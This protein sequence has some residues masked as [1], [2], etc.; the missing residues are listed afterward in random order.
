MGFVTQLA[1]LPFAILIQIPLIL[2]GWILK[3]QTA[4]KSAQKIPLARLQI[5]EMGFVIQIAITLFAAM[6]LEI[7]GIAPLIVK[8]ILGFQDDLGLNCL[9]SCN[10][11]NCYYGL[12]SCQE[13]SPGCNSEMLGDS[14]CD[15]SCNIDLCNY[16]FGDCNN[17]QCNKDC[18]SWMIGDNNCNEECNNEACNWDGGDCDCSQGCHSY[19]KNNGIFK[20]NCNNTA[21]NYDGGDC[22][23]CAPGCLKSILGDGICDS[24]CNISGCHYD[25]YDC[26]CSEGCS[27]ESYG[28]CKDSCMNSYCLYDTISETS[29]CQ[30]QNLVLFSLHYAFISKNLSIN[31]SPENCTNTTNCIISEALDS[32][33]CHTNCKASSCIYSWNQCTEYTCA[34]SNCLSCN[35]I[36][37][38]DCFKCNTNTYQFYGYCL[39]SCPGGH[40]PI[41][42]LGNYP[43]CLIP[44]D[45][46]TRENP[47]VY[48]VTSKTST[49]A[50]EGN[51]TF[52]NPFASVSL[53][54]ASIYTKYSIVYLLNDG[55]HYLT[56]A[57]SSNP[58]STLLSDPCN[59]LIRNYNLTSLLI[60]SYDN[61][62]ILLKTKAGSKFPTFTITNITT[63]TIKNIIFNGEDILSNCSASP[64]CSYCANITL[65]SDGSYYND[66]GVKVSSFLASSACT[67]YHSPTLFN[68]YFGSKL[69]L[70][71]VNFISWRMELKSII[72]SY[73]GNITFNNVNFDNIRCN[74][75]PQTSAQSGQTGQDWKYAVV[76]FLDCGDEN[77]NCGSFEYANGIVSRL[78]NGYE[79]GAAQFSGFLSADKI[80]TVYLENVTFSSNVVYNPYASST[81]YSLIKLALF[82][83]LEVSHCVFQKNAANYGL[84][85]LSP[86]TLIFRNDVNSNNELIDLLLFHVY[87]HDTIFENNYGQYAGIFS[88]TYKSQ[89]QNILLKNNV[90]N[91]NG[92]LSGPIMQI[93]NQ[94]L[95]SDYIVD[96]KISMNSTNG[97]Y[98]EAIYKKREFILKDSVITNNYSGGKGIFDITQLVNIRIYNLTVESNGSLKTQNINTILWDYYVADSN[99]YTKRIVSDAASIDCF[100]LWSASTCYN[101]EISES[102]FQA[103]M[104]QNSTPS[105][106]YSQVE[107]ANI[108]NCIFEGNI[109][110]AY[111]SGVC[112]VSSYAENM[113]IL[114]KI[115]NNNTNYHSQG[116]GPLTFLYS[117]KNVTI[118]DTFISKNSANYSSGIGFMGGSLVLDNVTF[119][120][121]RAMLGFGVIYFT[122]YTEIDTHLLEIK[123]SVFE[124]NQIFSVN[125]GAIYLLGNLLTQEVITLSIENTFFMKNSAPSGSAIY[126]ES[127]VILSDNS[128][129]DSCTFSQNSAQN[130]GTIVNLSQ[131]GILNIS[132]SLF[133][134]NYAELGSALYFASS[135]NV[136]SGKSRM[137]F[138]SCT[139]NL[140]SGKNVICTNDMA[141][142]SYIE[143]AK[144]IFQKNE[145]VAVYLVSDYW[146]DTESIIANSTMTDGA[147]YLTSNS[148]VYCVS[149]S[150][151]NNTSTKNAGAVRAEGNSYFY[152]NNCI[153][154]QNSAKN[155]G[156]LYFDQLSYFTIEN[157]VFSNNHCKK[158]GQQFMW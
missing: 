75:I 157:S 132:N 47:A 81:S 55:V 4:L 92:V 115:F 22:G 16:D 73:G 13:C 32:S 30:N 126:I 39:T 98:V 106:V 15:K 148:T 140:N 37:L 79:Y 105:L 66:Q 114:N 121:N 72:A 46:S 71:N 19:M 112:V 94:Y 134:S 27:I 82:R 141:I 85:Y 86:T 153:F 93:D 108:T 130:K 26:G 123:N 139:F 36:S 34:D 78:N 144:C 53:A 125:A 142:Y 104:C 99:L 145:G 18:E 23:E 101:Y 51:G 42:L 84:I 77:Y 149:T 45:Y 12:G 109:G 49:D 54:L 120:A 110:S 158:K 50:Y 3:A 8:F 1:C 63:L 137:I 156:A 70:E 7:V 9:Q 113:W 52:S 14:I 118:M 48:Y 76:Y 87:I 127:S 35:S 59:P 103:N 25:N 88:I 6:I 69:S 124:E 91:W 68:L 41:S 65:K 136:G 135:A 62:T 131:Y 147:V 119:E 129:I 5:L 128:R 138:N 20:K 56:C 33:R 116:A 2:Q 143:T 40:E 10:T 28:Q 96:T 74:W 100:A 111:Q 133:I 117:L 95:Y 11:K 67:S 97:T 64:Y 154:H 44:K 61:S 17:N 24:A 43:V 155:G 80:R 21:C 89:L 38:G 122:V 152:C 58:V 83:S 60:S 146:K 151:I 107:N 31:V 90:I 29:Q 102:I 150:F 57:N